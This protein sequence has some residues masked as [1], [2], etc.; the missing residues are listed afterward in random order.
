ME[1]RADAFLDFPR[2]LVFSTYRDDLPRFV[3]FLPSV[4]R[5]EV[6]S[7]DDQGDTA[8]L[9]NVWYGGGEIPAAARV[10]LSESMLAWT[11]YA[12]WNA[13]DHT[14]TWRIETH[15]FRDAVR[16]GGK[17][18]FVVDGA[19]TRLEIRGELSI[20]P[21]KVKGVPKLLAG[22]VKK[23]VEAFL[24]EKITPNL[25]QVSS[26]LSRYLEREKKA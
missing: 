23:A 7:R 25:L 18:R 26:G 20:D 16:C 13:S 2:D 15:S 6:K 5:I 21:A 11:D 4:R 10:V 17:N 8:E 14:C 3:E 9:V 22:T 19:G 12:L 1:L 24:V